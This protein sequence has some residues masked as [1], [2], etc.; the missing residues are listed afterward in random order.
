MKNKKWILILIIL[1][2]SALWIII[3]SG[4]I[5]SKKLNYFGPKKAIGE[6]TVY[7]S[8]PNTTFYQANENKTLFLKQFDTITYPILV[9]S[10]IKPKYA[11]DGFRI[12]GL[13]DYTQYK[14]DDIEKLPILLVFPK[15]DSVN[16][17]ENNLKDSLNFSLNNIEQC[18]WNASSFD[19]LNVQYFLKK[20]FYIDYSFFVL[21]DEKRR[22]RGYYDGRYV[23]EIKRLLG[24]YRH[25]RIKEAKK[26]LI[27]EN[28]IKDNSNE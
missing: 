2:P 9:L 25:L 12:G 14:K 8:L 11:K 21:L 20:P 5:N 27:N 15:T 18:Y 3:E 1:L 17:V 6:D 16:V 13:T 7:Y 28:K 26:S 4:T 22:I 23:A 19:S 10:F 24:E